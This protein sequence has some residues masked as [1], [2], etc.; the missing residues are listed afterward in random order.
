MSHRIAVSAP[1]LPLTGRDHALVVALFPFAD[2]FGEGHRQKSALL[3]SYL[4]ATAVHAAE[5]EAVAGFVPSS[6]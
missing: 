1:Y 5:R 2:G 3:T 6:V 4:P